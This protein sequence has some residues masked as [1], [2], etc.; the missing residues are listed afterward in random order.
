MGRIHPGGK[1]NLTW[2]HH[3]HSCSVYTGNVSCSGLWLGE[4]FHSKCIPLSV[5]CFVFFTPLKKKVKLNN[6]AQHANGRLRPDGALEVCFWAQLLVL[7]RECKFKQKFTVIWI[8]SYTKGENYFCSSRKLATL[9]EGNFAKLDIFISQGRLKGSD[10][11]SSQ[12]VLFSFC[13]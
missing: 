12:V 6:L 9:C 11:N 10:F 2:G 13:F 5:C 3:T 1:G 8:V 4:W 7:Q